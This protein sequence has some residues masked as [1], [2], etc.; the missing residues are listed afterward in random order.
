[1]SQK[2]LYR[3]TGTRNLEGWWAQAL[4]REEFFD[5]RMHAT[6]ELFQVFQSQHKS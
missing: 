1:M 2:L 3:N 6:V 5:D 4:A